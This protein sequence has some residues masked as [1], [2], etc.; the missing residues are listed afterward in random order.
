MYSIVL[1]V[2]L[3]QLL[4]DYSNLDRKRMAYELRNAILI[5]HGCLLLDIH[6]SSK[7]SHPAIYMIIKA[8]CKL[9]QTHATIPTGIFGI[10]S[11]LP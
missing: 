3:S 7:V 9:L 8:V 5:I 11:A 6:S 2:C 10:P 4:H 1:V